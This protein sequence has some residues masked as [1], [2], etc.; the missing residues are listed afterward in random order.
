VARRAEADTFDAAA[1]DSPCPRRSPRHLKAIASGGSTGR[2]KVIVDMAPGVAG[3]GQAPA[4]HVAGRHVLMNPG[5]LYHA[6]P[7]GMTCFAM[8]WGCTWS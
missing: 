1:D 5:P 8:G 4:G 7:F 2:P 6:A 3:P